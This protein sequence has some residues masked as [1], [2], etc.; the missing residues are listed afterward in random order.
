MS[1]TRSCPRRTLAA[2]SSPGFTRRR[3]KNHVQPKGLISMGDRLQRAKGS[4]EAA[5]GQIKRDT[6]RAAGR[7]GKQTRG[8]AEEA[9]GKAENAV[10]KA[11]SAAKKATR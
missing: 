3:A 7:P 4:A 2:A 11:R 8:A 9:K 1:I 6:G 5:K 10:G